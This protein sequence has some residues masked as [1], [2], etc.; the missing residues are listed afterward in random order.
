[1]KRNKVAFDLD[2]TLVD[3][4][5]IWREEI[6]AFTDVDIAN[7]K[8]YNLEREFGLSDPNNRAYL[9]LCHTTVRR[10]TYL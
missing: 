3:L 10:D 4:F 1:M 8:E 9:E 2:G 7:S 5:S 6:L